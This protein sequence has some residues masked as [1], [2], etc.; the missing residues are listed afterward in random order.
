MAATTALAVPP[1]RDTEGPGQG[2]NASNHVRSKDTEGPGQGELQIFRVSDV[3]L[4]FARGLV[5]AQRETQW[6]SP[7]L[8]APLTL[9]ARDGRCELPL[10]FEVENAAPLAST[11]F[12][13]RIRQLAATASPTLPARALARLTLEQAGLAGG[14]R[15]WV[16]TTLSLHPDPSRLLVELD[17]AQLVQEANESN[18]DAQLAF[19]V[20]DSCR[21]VLVRP[22]ATPTPP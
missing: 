18:N 5:L 12:Q 3:D 10:S 4:R 20:D 2:E 13:I 11:A 19:D 22:R 7:A 8:A 16:R 14:S 15:R 6:Q 21:L 1:E 9:A 17:P